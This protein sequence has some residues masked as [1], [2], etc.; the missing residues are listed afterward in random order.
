MTSTTQAIEGVARDLLEAP[1]FAYVATLDADGA[2]HVIPVWQH[3]GAGGTVEL[4]SA[5]GRVWAR[6]VE[7]DERIALVVPDKDN[8]YQY[9]EV[10]GRVSEMSRDGADDHIN[11]LSKKFLGQDEYP[12]R[13]ADEVRIR[14]V[15]QAERVR[16]YGDD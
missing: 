8:P 16:H 9:V 4:N 3:P 11:E 5:E 12:F 14:I 7:R 1:N 2:P 15:V 6:N 10:R 13:K